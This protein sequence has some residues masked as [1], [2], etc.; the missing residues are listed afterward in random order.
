MVRHLIK[1]TT[2]TE[3]MVPIHNKKLALTRPE[4]S[5]ETTFTDYKPTG[6]GQLPEPCTRSKRSY[7][8]TYQL[9]T[10]LLSIA[11]I[12]CLIGVIYLLI[13]ATISF[14]NN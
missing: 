10:I 14:K 3:E 13:F 11:L 8:P 4:F 5:S 9:S 1:I 2:K 12:L 7:F 6:F